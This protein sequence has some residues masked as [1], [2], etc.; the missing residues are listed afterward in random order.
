MSMQTSC[1][2]TWVNEERTFGVS[3]GHPSCEMVLIPRNIFRAQR[4]H[5]RLSCNC[6]VE[7]HARGTHTAL[8]QEHAMHPAQPTHEP[9]TRK[10]KRDHTGKRLVASFGLA[11]ARRRALPELVA[12]S[13]EPHKYEDEQ[14]DRWKSETKPL[15]SLRNHLI[16]CA[17]STGHVP[18]TCSRH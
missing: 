5:M 3:S 11:P 10:A 2:P 14:H 7:P 9:N 6:T 1:T 17:T 16:T 15:S 13:L 12:R 18:K 4:P 8:S